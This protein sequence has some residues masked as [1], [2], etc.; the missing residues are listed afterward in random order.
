M[1]ATKLQELRT[2]ITE[3][4]RVRRDSAES[5]PYIAAGNELV[6]VAARQNHVIFGRRGCGKSL[7]LLHSAKG[8]TATSRCI[9]LN[10]EDFKRHT[11]PNVLIEILESIFGELS[12][13]ATGWFGKKKRVRELLEETKGVLGG[14]RAQ[15]DE[16]EEKVKES[17]SRMEADKTGLN[18]AF[19]HR[20]GRESV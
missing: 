12:K 16:R 6:D 13:N 2:V 17:A 10:C 3:N 18:R 15:D 14:L 20:P 19:P 8:L 1:T 11:F 4:L 5:I 9:Y 7:L